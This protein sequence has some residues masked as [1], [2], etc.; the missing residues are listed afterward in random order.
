M[1]SYDMKIDLIYGALDSSD[2]FHT[3]FIRCTVEYVR[4]MHI[5]I[6]SRI[7][8]F[9]QKTLCFTIIIRSNCWY[10]Q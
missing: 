1:R 5:G 4:H 6:K 9:I 10:T 7:T 3:E 2:V 8:Y